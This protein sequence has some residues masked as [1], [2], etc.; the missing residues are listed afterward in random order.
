MYNEDKKMQAYGFWD[1]GIGGLTKGIIISF[2]VTLILLTAASLIITYTGVSEN[3][4]PA[5][6]LA[7]A[8]IS[9][10][11]GS[12]ASAKKTLSRGYL[13][14]ALCGG[15]YIAI[16]YI[17][18]SLLS[19]RIDFTTHTAVLFAIGIVVGALGGIIGINSGGRRK[20]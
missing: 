19:E 11:S 20:R 17:I 9:I 6:S 5:V 12:I 16:L 14:G 13:N 2:A 18:A 3:V 10:V 8:V 15:I 7:S 4:I 1:S